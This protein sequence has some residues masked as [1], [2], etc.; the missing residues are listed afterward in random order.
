M[1]HLLLDG[2]NVT[3]RAF[4]LSTSYVPAATGNFDGIRAGDIVLQHTTNRSLYM[5]LASGAGYTS[6]GLP[7]PA[8]GYVP[9]P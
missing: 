4:S 5:W 7:T 3:S 2:S 8:S 1:L 6:T 9:V